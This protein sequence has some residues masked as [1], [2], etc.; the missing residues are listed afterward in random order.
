MLLLLLLFFLY[1]VY[2]PVV[3]MWRRRVAVQSLF[4]AGRPPMVDVSAAIAADDDTIFA[5]HHM[6]F[7]GALFNLRVSKRNKLCFTFY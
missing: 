5:M 1:S 4:R 3:F 6:W 7:L 2:C